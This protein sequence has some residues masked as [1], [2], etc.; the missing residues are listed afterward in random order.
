VSEIESGLNE[1]S[2]QEEIRAAIR[3]RFEQDYQN[4]NNQSLEL[5]HELNRM[6]MLANELGTSIE[7]A[8]AGSGHLTGRIIGQMQDMERSAFAENAVESVRENPDFDEGTKAFEDEAVFTALMDEFETNDDIMTTRM[9]EEGRQERADKIKRKIGGALAGAG[10]GWFIGSGKA[11]EVIGWSADKIEDGW[12]WMSSLFSDNPE[13]AKKAASSMVGDGDMLNQFA[14][15]SSDG[16]NAMFATDITDWDGPTT[17]ND[18]S[19]A[20]SF[21]EA[22]GDIKEQMQDLDVFNTVGGANAPLDNVEAAENLQDFLD[23]DI[24]NDL[25]ERL[26]GYRPEDIK[27]SLVV[28]PGETMAVTKE[29]NLILEHADGEVDTLYNGTEDTI[30]DQAFKENLFGDF[31]AASGSEGAETADEATTG[32]GAHNAGSEEAVEGDVGSGAHG[33]FPGGGLDEVDV[34]DADAAAEG[35][36]ELAGGDMPDA[37][38]VEPAGLDQSGIDIPGNIDAVSADSQPANGIT[39]GAF[40]SYKEALNNP[41]YNPEYLSDLDI[42]N[43]DR[44]QFAQ[45]IR[46][47]SELDQPLQHLSEIAS[48][49]PEKYRAMQALFDSYAEANM[50]PPGVDVSG[51]ADLEGL[52]DAVQ[53]H[54][55]DNAPAPEPPADDAGSQSSEAPGWTSS[56]DADIPEQSEPS[57]S[58]TGN[59]P[60]GSSGEQTG[61]EVAGEGR[62]AEVEYP[63]DTESNAEPAASES[64]Q[65][66]SEVNPEQIIED[67]RTSEAAQNFADVTQDEY[68]STGYPRDL[69]SQLSLRASIGEMSSDFLNNE[70]IHI[71]GLENLAK[72]FDSNE[73]ASLLDSIN[74][75]VTE[76]NISKVSAGETNPLTSVSVALD[77][78]LHTIESQEA[79]D[80][81]NS[82]SKEA[83]RATKNY[84]DTVIREAGE[85]PPENVW[86]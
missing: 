16:P 39:K 7:E 62:G 53:Q 57:Q 52:Y 8:A 5:K 19:K 27:E 14:P 75:L 49:E 12:S 24:P 66:A 37:D 59:Q 80:I 22:T 2:S 17:Y 4:E 42:P 63:D 11:G 1:E 35:G 26:D 71:E 31:D 83:I 44:D 6:R 78:H 72:H 32:L 58:D 33:D 74:Y 56:Q 20:R 86:E 82:P 84:V 85:G 30:N 3:D 23:T 38:A 29:G 9:E 48:N 25:A 67:A 69:F 76:Q 21:I 40:D 54:I 61:G 64:P 45:H 55:N 46:E 28:D 51:N 73:D 60:A 50:T 65:G 10:M 41:M 36:E 70:H 43:G 77:Y 13:A 15:E 18:A 81:G 79:V 68:V 34:P 47:L